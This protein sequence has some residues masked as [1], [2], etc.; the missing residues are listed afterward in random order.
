MGAQGWGL[1]SSS[2]I[3]VPGSGIKLGGLVFLAG[4]SIVLIQ[5]GFGVDSFCWKPW[6]F[7]RLSR[8]GL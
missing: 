3:Q 6:I 1:R 5:R 4:S 2:W 8:S 7:F